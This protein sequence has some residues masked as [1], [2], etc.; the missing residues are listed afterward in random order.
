ME[1]KCSSKKQ[2]E[3]TCCVCVDG[4]SLEYV[5]QEK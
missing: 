2:Q 4:H 3:R 1:K 5:M